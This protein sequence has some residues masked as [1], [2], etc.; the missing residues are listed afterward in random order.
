MC[1]YLK[2]IEFDVLTEGIEEGWGLGLGWWVFWCWLGMF[3]L[4][5]GGLGCPELGRAVAIV[6]DKV[7][8][9]SLEV[10]S[11]KIMLSNDKYWFNLWYKINL[12]MRKRTG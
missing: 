9:V 11:K 7:S 8:E 3:M 12:M 1:T 5:E 10:E 6:D 2:G 4:D